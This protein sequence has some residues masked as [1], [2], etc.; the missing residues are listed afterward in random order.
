MMTAPKFGTTRSCLKWSIVSAD[1]Q[2]PGREG[3]CCRGR[4]GYEHPARHRGTDPDIEGKTR[5]DN[6]GK[7]HLPAGT[8][9]K[10]QRLRP[11]RPTEGEE[12]EMVWRMSPYERRTRGNALEEWARPA[13]SG[14][15]TCAVQR[16]SG[17]VAVPGAFPDSEPGYTRLEAGTSLR[18]NPYREGCM[19]ASA[20]ASSRRGRLVGE[21][22]G[23]NRTRE[24]RPS[25]IVGGPGET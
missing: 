20:L 19:R 5:R 22:H 2:E 4:N 15:N 9:K 18:A 23:Q 25:G 12:R 14:G 17:H 6:V 10:L 11:I 16:G 8:G 1:L 24:I 13:H 7:D 21:S 3:R